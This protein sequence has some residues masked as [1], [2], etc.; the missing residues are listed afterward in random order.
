M[1]PV[2][3]AGA[4]D[5]L[6]VERKPER[7]NQMQGGASR[8]AGAADIAG[9]PVDFGMDENDV[10]AQAANI[11]AAGSLAVSFAGPERPGDNYET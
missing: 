8:Q 11:S 6:L 10:D 5:L 1:F 7:L 3:E 4:L 9:V 2:V